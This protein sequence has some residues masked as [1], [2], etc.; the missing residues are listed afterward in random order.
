MAQN[1]VYIP[2]IDGKD[3]WLSNYSS[4]Y[5]QEY[6]LMDHAG[7]LNLKRFKAS[8]DYS[9]DLIKLREIY[10][11]V[12]RNTRFSHVSQ[13]KEYC[14]RMINVTFDY[15]IKAFNR[16]KK[17]RYL[18]VGE[19]ADDIVWSDCVALR[20]QELLAIQVEQ[21]VATPLSKEILGKY[22]YY[23]NGCYH[24]KKNIKTI[25]SVAD[26]RTELYK[27]GFTCDGIKYVRW[28]RSSGSARVGKCLFIDEK[29]YPR[30]H[31]WELCGLTVKNGEY[32][33]LA[34]LESYISLTSSSII[35]T[36]PIKPE[37]IL[38]VADYESVFE[39]RVVNITEEDGQL[40]SK[41]EKTTI[42]NSIWDGQSLI[43][44]SL[45]GA[46]RHKG[47]LLL[48][49][50][51]FKSCC[52]NTNLQRWFEDNQITHPSQF[53]G[54]TLAEKIEDV[55]LITTPSSI[56]YLK[57]STLKK[58]LHLLSHD[59]GIVKYE[60]PT[61]FMKGQ[62]VQ[63]HYQLINSIQLN[64]KEMQALLQPTFDF[65]TLLK[66]DPAVLRYWIKFHIE[67]EIQL[68]FIDSKT[69]IIYKMMS[70]NENFYKTKLYHEFKLDFLKSF[71]NNLKYGHILVNGNYATLCGNPIELL[72]HALGKFDGQSTMEKGSIF[73]KRFAWNEVLLGSRSPHISASN[74]LLAKNQYHA[75]IDT[76]MNATK[77]IVYIN[78]IRENILQQLAGCDFDSDQILLTNNQILVHAAWRN[79][80]AF[81]VA[82]CSVGGMK[83]QRRYT[84][85]D[86]A[87]LDVKTSKNL[88]GEIIN[89]SQVL[90]SM[91]WDKLAKG[92]PISEIHYIY[93]DVCKLSIMSGIEIDK[94]KKEFL[95]DNAYELSKIRLKYQRV[96][97]NETEG[98]TILPNF[99]EHIARQKGYE[100]TGKKVYLKHETSMDYLQQWVKAYRFSK[101]NKTSKNVFLPFSDVVNTCDFKDKNVKS[102]AIHQILKEIDHLN[103][104]IS[105]TYTN[106]SF[107]MLEKYELMHKLR[108]D[109][110][111]YIGNL[112]LNRD[113]MI[114]LLQTIEKQ[115]HKKYHRLLFY[116]LFGY[117]NVAFYALL[118]NNK[119]NLPT[120]HRDENGPIEIFGQRFTKKIQNQ[121]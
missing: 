92:Q 90:N 27:N 47:M 91:I 40:Q 63:T 54:F 45:L 14:N 113:T 48:R 71:T 99:F 34:A 59:F 2:Q 56:K 116:T 88:I 98:K 4:K 72:L 57:F 97:G 111:D 5:S 52:F 24:E 121:A 49:N 29:L 107:S 13:N 20:N 11:K 84:Q 16:M 58:W 44:P 62:L 108:Q 75:L 6:R 119:K 66:N 9:L 30:F 17:N 79:R 70:V 65:M 31:K 118:Q 89:T 28:K 39:D 37:N 106:P 103:L 109:A 96:E 117:P 18:K 43:D 105:A 68:S 41:Q 81:P 35:D 101:Q 102:K 64:E 33:D 46:Y 95:I 53:N 15:S 51:F 19:S 110:I 112:H 32:V 83:K 21:E 61:H 36:L 55:L 120:I 100:S 104:K 38:I 23:E 74:V 12:Y 50:R 25:K 42:Q 69:D 60:K 114:A 1:S 85:E 115:E 7:N 3:L 93:L 22:F 76:Y 94:A 73:S 86:L 10:N 26:I 77:E 78:S 87:D 80:N 8:F 67:D 82:V